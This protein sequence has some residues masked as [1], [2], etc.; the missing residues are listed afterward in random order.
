MI[1]SGDIAIRPMKD[2]EVDY[3]FMVKWL[4]D[5]RVYEFIHGKP[6]DLKWVKNK[7]GPRAKK[8]KK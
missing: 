5:P 1:K 7:Y 6:K 4:S 3:Q 2:E 8:E